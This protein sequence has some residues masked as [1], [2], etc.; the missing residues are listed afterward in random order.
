[1]IV[2]H[3]RTDTMALR[4]EPATAL[5]DE[6]VTIQVTGAVPGVPIDITAAMTGHDGNR[7]S[8]TATFV[9]NDAGCVDVTTD[10]TVSGSY[11][12]VDRMG[13]IWSMTPAD[14]A[15][16]VGGAAV[17]RGAGFEVEITATQG[18]ASTRC[19]IQRRWLADGVTVTPIDDAGLTA[20]L[21]LPAKASSG[22]VILLSGSEGGKH[23]EWGALVASRGFT[24]LTLAYF[25]APGVP[26]ELC[27]IPLEYFERAVAWLKVRPEVGDGPIV[28]MGGSR[29]G[30]LALLLGATIDNIDAVV[31]IAPSANLWAGLPKRPRLL[32]PPAWT[33]HGRPLPYLGRGLP[34]TLWHIRSIWSAR[35]TGTPIALRSYFLAMMKNDNAVAKTSIAVERIRGPVLVISGTDDQMY[36]STQA[37]EQIIE[38]LRDA[39]RPFADRHCNYHGAGHQIRPPYAPTTTSTGQHPIP[40]L[41]WAC[42]GNPHDDAI[43]CEQSWSEII[44]FLD[45]VIRA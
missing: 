10:A 4:V 5:I 11:V 25:G 1:M 20:N 45:N 22:A 6:P 36:P 34:A 38:R 35:K 8:A 31:A 37:A 16:S 39:H 41:A 7:L 18:S 43:A 19:L 33:H 32:G 14:D 40:G 17:A 3:G 28:V 2:E 9:A 13:L 44:A 15:A 30:E 29:G 12:G 42:G 21:F 23:W 26:D 27:A 24:A